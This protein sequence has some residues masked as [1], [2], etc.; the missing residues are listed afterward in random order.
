MHLCGNIAARNGLIL[1]PFAVFLLFL[2]IRQSTLGII[3]EHGNSSVRDI[4]PGSPAYSN[5]KLRPGDVILKVIAFDFVSNHARQEKFLSSP[6]G[7]ENLAK[8]FRL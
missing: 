5:D 8:L 2:R 7:V 4:V 6:Y 1:R 3:L